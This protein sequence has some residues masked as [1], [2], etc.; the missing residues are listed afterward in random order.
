MPVSGGT[1]QRKQRDRLRKTIQERS[2]WMKETAHLRAAI[3]AGNERLAVFLV[4]E[5]IRDREEAA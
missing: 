1:M 4:R 2:A 3:E 5:I